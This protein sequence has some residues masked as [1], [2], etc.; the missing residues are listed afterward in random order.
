LIDGLSVR[1]EAAVRAFQNALTGV[2][3]AG[4]SAGDGLRFAKTQVYCD[5]GFHTDSAVLV[6]VTTPLPFRLFKTQHFIATD[7]RVVVTDADSEH[8]IVREINGLSAADEYARILGISTDQLEPARFAAWPV[9]VM[10]DGT[11]YVRAIQKA[12]P[13]GSLTF[14]CAIEN[15]V[16]LRVAKGIDL[17]QNLQDTFD[18][19]RQEIGAPQLVIGCDCILRKLEISQ[20]AVKDRVSALLEQNNL[21]GFATYGEQFNG[22]HVNQTMV[23]IAI[24]APQRETDG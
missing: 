15:G 24:G 12:N 7:E 16:V 5:G 17:L 13:D 20:S 21:V 8:R 6:L 1:E 2:P 14:F 18:E 22:I 3:V 23:G 9:V 10:I 11:N 4:G 19:V